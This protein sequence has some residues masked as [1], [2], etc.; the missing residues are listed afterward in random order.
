MQTTRGS[1][2][3]LFCIFCFIFVIKPKNCVYIV[4][5]F[6]CRTTSGHKGAGTRMR[7]EKRSEISTQGLT[8]TWET[9]TTRNPTKVRQACHSNKK[10]LKRKSRKRL[11]N[12][13]S[14]FNFNFLHRPILAF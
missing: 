1:R 4:S 7:R 14:T 8:Q 12:I 6:V 13:N 5:A 11:T 3:Q 2:R 10:I 9:Q